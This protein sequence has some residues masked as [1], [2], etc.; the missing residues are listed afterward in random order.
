MHSGGT[1]QGV[2]LAGRASTTTTS[3]AIA[4]VGF[5]AVTVK[6]TSPPTSSPVFVTTAVPSSGGSGSGTFGKQ[7]LPKNGLPDCQPANAEPPP[8][9]VRASSVVYLTCTWTQN[10]P[11]GS[12]N[13]SVP[14]GK[15]AGGR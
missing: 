3:G 12:L 14:N 13:G 9:S 4:V 6:T 15:D 11:S 2:S 5:V 10:G 7:R 1:V 8:S